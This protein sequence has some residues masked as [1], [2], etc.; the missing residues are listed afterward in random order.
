MV[1][2]NE[3]EWYHLSVCLNMSTNWFFDDYENDPV[4]AANMDTICESCPVRR[5][6]LRE[7]IENQE[8]G[9][10]G[11]VFLNNGRMEP[12]RNTHKTEAQWED[13]RRLIS[14]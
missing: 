10:W 13:I 7:G 6:C 9:L 2:D 3:L 14:E 12:S 8:Y 1:E 4:F 5:M 11:G